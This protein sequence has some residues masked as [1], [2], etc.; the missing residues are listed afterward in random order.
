MIK[1]LR[2]LGQGSARLLIGGALLAMTVAISVPAPASAS[3]ESPNWLRLKSMNSLPGQDMCLTAA[4]DTDWSVWQAICEHQWANDVWR[5][6]PVGGGYYNIKNAWNKCLDAYGFNHDNYGRVTTWDCNGYTNQ[7]WKPYFG[8]NGFQ[9]KPRHAEFD[10]GGQGKCLDV[11]GF[12]HYG[13]APVVLWDCLGGPNQ[14]WS[15]GSMPW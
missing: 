10:N 2:Q 15:T 5:M 4:A 8:V 13:G 11:Y 9:L 12:A 7:Q 6:V 1:S 3:A 14:M